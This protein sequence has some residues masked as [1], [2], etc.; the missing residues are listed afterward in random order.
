MAA[1]GMDVEMD[2]RTFTMPPAP[3]SLGEE[4]ISPTIPTSLISRSRRRARTH[5]A[6]E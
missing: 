4:I 1:V 3:E 2:D 5:A 6:V